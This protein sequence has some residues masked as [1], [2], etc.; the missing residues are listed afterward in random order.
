MKLSEIN[1]IIESTIASVVKEATANKD[2]VSEAFHFEGNKTL[3]VI[4]DITIE[5][6]VLYAVIKYIGKNSNGRKGHLPISFDILKKFLLGKKTI[7]AVD[8][9]SGGQRNKMIGIQR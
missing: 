2:V 1:T 4:E 5:D 8:E 6:N 7:I 9:T 3:A